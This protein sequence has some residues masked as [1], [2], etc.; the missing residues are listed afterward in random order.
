MFF[1][2]SKK[3]SSSDATKTANKDNDNNATATALLDQ[4][5]SSSSTTTTT[6]FSDNNI[7]TTRDTQKVASADT[8]ETVVVNLG[9]FWQ[10]WSRCITFQHQRDHLYRLGTFD[11]CSVQWNDYTAVLA[12]KF[13]NDV[14]K[15]KHVVQS[16]TLYQNKKAI[17][18]TV[19]VIWEAKDTPSWD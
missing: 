5:I 10:E 8:A 15:A 13:T 7:N 2:S 1:S 16:T 17:S 14:Q 12:V 11:D 9:E 3:S 19:G 18:P 6:T 4:V